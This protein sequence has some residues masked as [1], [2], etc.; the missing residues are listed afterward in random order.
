MLQKNDLAPPARTPFSDDAEIDEFLAM[1]GRFERGEIDADAWRAY[2]VPRGVYAQRQGEDVHMLRVKVPQGIA[3]APQL[4]ALADVARRFSRGWGHLTTRQNLQFHF[5]RSQDLEPAMRRLAQAGI[6]TSGACGNSVRNV[7]SCPLAGV[8]AGEI[9]DPTPYAEAVTRRF[10]RHPLAMSLPR[11][12]KIGFEG[13]AEDHVATAI[14]DIGFRAR[15]RLEGGVPVRGFSVTVAGGT[16]SL[17]SSGALFEFLPAADVLVVAEAI[18]RVFHAH[19]DREH[20]QRNRLKFLVRQLGF[21]AFRELVS[22]EVAR[23]R[24]ERSARLPFDA[25]RP[26]EPA[27]PRHAAPAPPTPAELAERLRAEVLRGPGEPPRVESALGRDPAVEARFRVTNVRPQRQ[28]GRSVVALAPPHGD[29]TAA[30]LETI[31]ELALAY[32]EGAVRFTNRGHVLLRWVR[33]AD[34]P[35]LHERLAAAGL[36]RD[37]AGSAAD[38]V[39]CP[40]ADSCRLAVTRTRG[41]A[42]ALERHVRSALPVALDQ[43]VHVNVSGCPNG[44]SQHHVA[45]IGLQGSARKVGGRAAPQYFVLLGGGVGEHGATF[46]KLAA[47]V[48][49]RRLP[50][51]VERLVALYL[52]QREDGESAEAF[53]ARAFDRAREVLAPFQEL[54][55]EEAR[56]EDFQEAGSNEPFRSRGEEGERVA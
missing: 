28:P 11:K 48:P 4:R 15:V 38:V 32:G 44:C 5:V 21:A 45:A 10:L 13:C 35:A 50:Q 34:L 6:T 47:K 55:P 19:G 39:A 36:A 41:T 46:G 52:A 14:H 43:P 1:L 22:E 29:V 16:A 54:R 12:F 56:E 23:V 2:R 3:D 26:P 53:F 40:G 25:G 49:A 27:E 42:A 8:S 30:Q 33:D 17:C 20:R 31:A 37:G 9:F 51:A 24:A 18:V 7:V